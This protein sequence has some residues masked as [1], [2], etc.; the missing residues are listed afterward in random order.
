LTGVNEENTIMKKLILLVYS[1]SLLVTLL[2]TACSKDN[3][4]SAKPPGIW[5]L[6]KAGIPKFVG[7]N[8]LDLSKINRVSKFR[9][10]IGH[11]Y[12]DSFEHC[13]SM[14]HYFEPQSTV[15]W[16]S[17]KIYAPV[18]GIITR[19]DEEWAGT[20][21]EIAS[22]DYPA[23]R[24]SIFHINKAFP[25]NVNNKVSA[26]QLLGTHIGSQTYS[27]IAV[28]LNDSTQQYRLV[29]YFEVITD[30]IFKQYS[31]RGVTTREDMIIPKV[32]REENP[33]TC[34]VDMFT[35]IDTLQNW[36]IL[37]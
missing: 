8:Y 22:D 7:T 33:L 18:T 14:K 9:S 27:D 5:D 11:D 31:D 13:R 16:A 17:I 36:F 12:S 19:V 25:F 1:I 37:K 3:T 26:G 4:S 6:D 2:L 28:M 29:S 10:S 15:D 34:D 20:K 35:S 24:F 21:L 32:I 23:F 30:S